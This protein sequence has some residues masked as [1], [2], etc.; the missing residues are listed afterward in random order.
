MP[1]TVPSDDVESRRAASSLR[2]PWFLVACCPTNV[3]RTLASLAAYVATTDADGVQVHQYVGGRI[4]ATLADGRRLALEMTT[5]YPQTGVV[6]VRVI[7][8]PGDP[9]S[10]TLR[11]PAWADGATVTDPSGVR[12]GAAPGT[13]VVDVRSGPAT[14]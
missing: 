6:H 8:A 2:E 5:D 13:V 9:S 14:R 4:A 10:L 7:E 1:G 12:H 3:A 11:V